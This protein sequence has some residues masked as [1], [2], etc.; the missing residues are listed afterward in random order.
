MARVKSTIRRVKMK[1]E[2]KVAV[3]TG[4][5]RGI[6]RS[7]ALAFA[8]EGA[9]LVLSARTASQLDQ[10]CREVEAIGRQ[11][12]VVPGDVSEVKDIDNLVAKTLDRFGAPD[13]IVNNA[14]I[15]PNAL[16]IEYDDEVWVKV[17][18]TNLIANFMI[19]KRFI[20]TM[21]PRKTG[22][23]INIASIAGKMGFPFSS[24]YIASKHGVVGLTKAAAIEM[25]IIGAPGITVNAICPGA[26]RT[27]MLTGEHGLFQWENK[28]LG[29]SKEEAER[30]LITMNVQAR[31]LDPDEIAAMAV[32]LASD[33]AGGITGQ[34]I[35]VDGGQNMS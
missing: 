33:E 8:R 6:G 20:K 4:A 19:T 18:Q 26:T 5:G 12:I 27:E 28:N 23:I 24:A 35:S 10:V 2:N 13:I 9:N 30:S 7:I 17:I 21:I 16:L 1:L 25:G 3:V 29:M 14:G 32:Y 31:M 34:A 22:R 11:V 15:S